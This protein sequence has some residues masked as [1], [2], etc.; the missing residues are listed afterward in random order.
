MLVI[1]LGL[2]LLMIRDQI[3]HAST[4]GGWF[5]YAPNAGVLVPPGTWEPSHQRYLTIGFV[6]LWCAISLALL[7]E[8]HPRNKGDDDS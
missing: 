1:A 5:N 3:V 2:V 7:G 6:V 4:L 8:S